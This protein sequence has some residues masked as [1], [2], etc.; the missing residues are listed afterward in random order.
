DR[1]L[2]LLVI[3]VEITAQLQNTAYW[4]G[5]QPIWQGA[6]VFNITPDNGIIFKGGVTQLQNGQLPTWQ[7]NN[8]FITRTLYIGNVLYTIS[9]NMV[10]MNSLSDLSE[11]GSVSLA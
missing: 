3:P 5:Y 11:L 2:N 10:Q 9:N 4:Y 6:Y 1:T 7:D 8:L